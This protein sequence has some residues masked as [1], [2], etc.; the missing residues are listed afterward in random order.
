MRAVAIVPAAGQGVRMR[1]DRP[2]A[3]IPLLGRPMLAW[4][5]RPFYACGLFS[6]ILVA[7]LPGEEQAFQAPLDSIA[8]P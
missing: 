8:E 3:L 6:E 2:K 5:L 4:T 7:C 1:S